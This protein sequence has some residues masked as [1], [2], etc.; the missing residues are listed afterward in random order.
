MES[1]QLDRTTCDFVTSQ[2]F[3]EYAERWLASNS[4][5]HVVTLNAEMV[6]EAHHNTA[7]KDAVAATDIRVP[8]GAGP[9]WA[10]RYLESDS[11]LL[12]SLMA[13]LRQPTHRVTGTDTLTELA[14]RATAANQTVYLLG[15]TEKEAQ[16]TAAV[17]TKQIPDIQVIVGPAHTFKLDGPSHVLA[18]IQEKAP[19]LLFVAYGAP[20]QTLWTEQN[21][22]K[23]PSVRVAV[24][25]G[26]AFSMIS[27]RT[28]R[29]PRIMRTANIEWLWRLI[30]QPHRLPRIIR[31]VIAFPRLM[32]HQKEEK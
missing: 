26:G 12:Q 24:G 2:E 19:G 9:I 21:K 7:F 4:F 14:R 28:P 32:Y 5:H 17:L 11:G 16:E 23:I 15:G 8:D 22:N 30:L 6:V 3:Y 10:K 27:G 20:N 13:F 29:A 18:D 25:V 31:A 1:V